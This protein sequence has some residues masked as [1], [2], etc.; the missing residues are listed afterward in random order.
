MLALAREIEGFGGIYYEPGGGPLVVALTEDNVGEFPAA[1]RAVLATLA[2]DVERNPSL[3]TARAE[4]TPEV[5]TRV[6]EY[7]FIELARHRARLRAP[8]FALPEVV[9]L[10]V[11]EEMNRVVIGLEDLSAQSAV[12]DVVAEMAIPLEVISFSRESRMTTRPDE[13][14]G[15]SPP[16]LSSSVETNQLDAPIADGKLRGGYQVQASGRK[17]VCTLGFTAIRHHNR[18]LA[19]VSNSHCS[20]IPWVLDSGEWWQPDTI[21]GIVVGVEVVDPPTRRCWKRVAKIV[22]W[23]FDCRNADASLMAVKPGV[24]IALGEIG[25]TNARQREC[26]LII[27]DYS[28]PYCSRNIDTS[29]PTISITETRYT[30][31]KHEVLDKIG[32][33]TGWTWGTV[34]ETCKDKRGD[35]GVWSLCVDK[36]DFRVAHGDSGGP[37]FK[38]LSDGTAQFMGIVFGMDDEISLSGGVRELGYFQDLERIQWDLGNLSVF[39]PGSPQVEIRGPREVRPEEEC[40]WMAHAQGLEPFRYRWS[41]LFGETKVD[42]RGPSISAVLEE[43]GRL[44]VTATDP[45]DRVATNALEV[46]VTQS[47]DPCFNDR[48]GDDSIFP[49]PPPPSR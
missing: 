35:T 36:V 25:R 7:S 32:S 37:V 17:T 39:D 28:V 34:K 11:D 14:F 31:V 13:P 24:S 47:A 27:L 40:M 43:S 4:P 9:S 6:V 8:L 42:A 41:G 15:E 26:S 45:Y 20:R 38:Y 3:T 5:V 16:R 12:L 49:T 29:N 19:F 44:E 10:A 46:E 21:K 30:S 23:P 22:P 48:G 2:A 33:T 1:R 18:G